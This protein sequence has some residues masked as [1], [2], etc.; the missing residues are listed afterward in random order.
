M[1]GDILSAGANILGGFLNRDAAKDAQKQQQENFN[2]N[3][4]LQKDFAQ[5]GIRWKVNDAEKAGI[6]P[7]YALGAQTHSF[8]PVSVGS[9]VDSSMGNAMAAAGQDLGRAINSTR[10]APE[11]ADAFSKTVQALSVQKMGLENELLASQIAKQKAALNPPM[12]TLPIPEAKKIEERP[13]LYMG[14]K[15]IMTDP[16]TSNMDDY[17]KRYGD[18]GL[19]SW[20]IPP[21][22]MFRDYL[23]TSGTGVTQD[24]F[25]RR[26]WDAVRNIKTRPQDYL[27]KKWR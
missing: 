24:S 18:E 25:A 14:G 1:L 11:R 8:S 17:S 5:A 7:L 22:I 12:P 2:T 4:Q 10:T 21:M 20:L 15:K 13:H 26:M 27:D 9:G 23:E 19:P 6:H 16:T 3:I